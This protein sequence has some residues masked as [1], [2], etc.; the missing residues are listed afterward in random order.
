MAH[1]ERG[2]RTR[3]NRPRHMW[4]QVRVR[5]A[6]GMT[7]RCHTITK[8]TVDN[9]PGQSWSLIRI[10][11]REV[12]CRPYGMTCIRY[13]PFIAARCRWECHQVTST[14]EPVGVEQPAADLDGSRDAANAR[15]AGGLM[16]RSGSESTSR[17]LIPVCPHRGAARS[18]R[19]AMR[20]RSSIGGA[21]RGSVVTTGS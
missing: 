5:Y 11:P 12:S 4:L 20:S 9:Y 1:S 7:A 21:E 15:S 8:P 10:R 17:V 2:H 16:A 6:P 3:N 14:T 19:L 13:Q 18:Y